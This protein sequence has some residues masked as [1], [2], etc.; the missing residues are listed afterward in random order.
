MA[1]F[2]PVL[3]GVFVLGTVT[4]SDEPTSQAGPEMNPGVAQSDA[5]IAAIRGRLSH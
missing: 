3:A 4:T 1:V 5:T 2:D